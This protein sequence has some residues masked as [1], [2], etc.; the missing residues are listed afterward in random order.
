M[1]LIITL[2]LHKLFVQI[3]LFNGMNRVSKRQ[4]ARKVDA[5]ISAND[6]RRFHSI[7]IINED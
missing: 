6:G 7:I 2:L 4:D 1:H 3:T 5:T